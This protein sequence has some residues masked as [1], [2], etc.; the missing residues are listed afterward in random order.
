[1]DL[2]GIKKDETTTQ[3]FPV[4]PIRDLVVVRREPYKNKLGLVLPDKAK[5]RL[6]TDQGTVVSV[7]P[8]MRAPL[9]GEHIPMS[10]QVGDEVMFG[11]YSGSPFK[12]AGLQYLLMPEKDI[13]AILDKHFDPKTKLKEGEVGGT[14][15]APSRIITPKR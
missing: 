2:I 11:E 10:V 9:T 8:G 15:P 6:A 3:E 14:P 13:V 7:G 1:M 4:R 12:H 5:E